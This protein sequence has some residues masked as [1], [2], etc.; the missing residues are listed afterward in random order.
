[1]IRHWTRHL[2]HRDRPGGAPPDDALARDQHL[3]P[4][5]DRGRAGDRAG[6]QVPRR[7]LDHDPGDGRLLHDHEGD[8]PP[9]RQGRRGAR[10]SRRT[11]RSCR[12]GCTRSCWSPS[13][14]SR[15]CGR[16]PT[17][18]RRGP[19]VLEAVFV[20]T[21]PAATARLLEEWDDRRIDV[22]LKV[23]Y[24]PYREIIRPIVDYT[25]SIRDANPRGVVAVYIPEYVV[26][27]LVGAAAAQPDRAAAQGPAAV[28]PRRDG[29]LGAL[30]AALVRGRASSAR[31][32]GCARSRAGDVRRGRV[33]SDQV[34]DR[35][36]R[37]DEPAAPAA[38]P[39]RALRWWG[40]GTT[41]RSARSPTAATASPGTTGPSWSSSGTRCPASGSSS[42]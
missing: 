28:H 32:G 16:W 15:R 41:S 12:P 7:R 3:R 17:P 4:R 19:N 13:C 40:S 39:A 38:G 21:D 29:H 30:P 23:L 2:K 25:R 9:L 6:H 1:M 24:S 11:T 35:R 10:P 27:P 42:R 20:D 37:T 34:K 5:D 36:A 26:G 33:L 8:P 22:P 18:R 31:S 14:T